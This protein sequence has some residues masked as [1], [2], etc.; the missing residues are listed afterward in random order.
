MV[1]L[2]GSEAKLIG[3]VKWATIE[4]IWMFMFK[5]LLVWESGRAKKKQSIL[6]DVFRGLNLAKVLSLKVDCNFGEATC[7]TAQ[8]LNLKLQVKQMNSPGWKFFCDR[9]C[10][11]IFKFIPRYT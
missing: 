1:S 3:S 11:F 9:C 6:F 5:I 10:F 8:S 2:W 7:V 4:L